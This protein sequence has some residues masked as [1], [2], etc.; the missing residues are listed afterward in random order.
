MTYS[1]Q[2]KDGC[3]YFD[4]GREDMDGSVRLK[5][6]AS[7]HVASVE[8]RI[9]GQWIHGSFELDKLIF[10]DSDASV[11]FI[12]S[13]GI[14]RYLI[15]PAYTDQKGFVVG[16]AGGKGIIYTSS[17]TILHKF[18]EG[19]TSDV[20]YNDGT[21]V[22][23]YTP[24]SPLTWL[25]VPPSNYVVDDWYVYPES[26]TPGARMRIEVKHTTSEVILFEN[27][28]EDSFLHHNG[29]TP[30]TAT[31][32]HFVVNPPMPLVKG[33][34]YD[35]KIEFSADVS[36]YGDATKI[37]ER[38]ITQPIAVHAISCFNKFMTSVTYN[39]GDRV[40]YGEGIWECKVNGTTGAWNAA[41]W[42]DTLAAVAVGA[43][44]D[45]I[46]TAWDKSTGV[47][48]TENQISD[49]KA[50]L[51]VETDPV[52]TAWDKSTGISIT[53]S[54]ISDK[55]WSN[56]G[57]TLQNTAGPTTFVFDDGSTALPRLAMTPTQTTIYCPDIGAH[58]LVNNAGI[59]HTVGA[60][61]VSYTDAGY[62]Y[63]DGTRI[64][65]DV[66]ATACYVY[67]PNGSKSINV[68]NTQIALTGTTEIQNGSLHVSDGSRTRLWTNP[69][70]T[71]MASP[72]GS[73]EIQVNNTEIEVTGNIGFENADSRIYSS[74]NIGYLEF[75]ELGEINW[76]K[77]GDAYDR[78]QINDT[79]YY[80]FAPAGS[81]SIQM[82]DAAI[83]L[84]DGTRDRVAVNSTAS[85]VISPDGD[86]SITVQNGS[87][88]LVGLSFDVNDRYRSR[89]NVGSD[90]VVINSPNATKS[91]TVDNSQILLTAD[92]KNRLLIDSSRSKLISPDGNKS[93][94]VSNNLIDNQTYWFNI[95]DF[96]R[97]RFRSNTDDVS[98]YSPNGVSNLVVS[99]A[100]T[101]I[102]G[103]T[104]V[105]A[106]NQSKSFIIHP[107]SAT[108]SGGSLT[109]KGTSDGASGTYESYSID[110]FWG[111]MRIFSSGNK[112]KVIRMQNVSDI[113]TSPN[114]KL[115]LYVYGNQLLE[116]DQGFNATNETATLS[117]GDVNHYLQAKHSTGLIMGSSNGLTIK[118]G[119]QDR[120][121]VNATETELLSPTDI[122]SLIVRD[123]YMYLFDGFKI[124]FHM[125][126][127]KTQIMS[128]DGDQ[129]FNVSNNACEV[130]EHLL[131]GLDLHVDRSA[132][133]DV[134]LDVLKQSTFGA[135]GAST[136]GN[137]TFVT[138]ARWA[139]NNLGTA[140][141]FQGPKNPSG[142]NYDD[143]NMQAW[144]GHLR[145]GLTSSSGR[146]LIV[147]NDGVGSIELQV[148][149][150]VLVRGNDSFD[151]SGET[152][153]IW[154][155]N[156]SNSIVA[157]YQDHLNIKG[158]NGVS[159]SDRNTADYFLAT[160]GNI[161][162]NNLPT[163]DPQI[164]GVLW[165]D[166]TYIRVSNPS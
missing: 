92:T 68:N 121:R 82:T 5:V 71:G 55:Y 54:Q 80:M 43:E 102:N 66:D 144:E 62:T 150:G 113:A 130:N 114:K 163:Y 165:L 63:H 142:G 85:S 37:K 123:T 91:I 75:A 94:A 13:D 145:M 152:A 141:R 119:T 38:Y 115:L 23:P 15:K 60:T 131:V 160:L 25:M 49:L 28:S 11:S 74:D 46:F 19:A 153:E 7:N 32:T 101:V 97:T 51:T 93:V 57:T 98:M 3:F 53:E 9:K 16:N 17:N 20:T 159:I 64:R 95:G 161:R 86:Q 146:S 90:S 108:Y 29:G 36:L 48:I 118:R 72:D 162:M 50:Y 99:N 105:C 41:N 34:N 65:V 126:N 2:V 128:A 107:Y 77:T 21:T 59:F 47:V 84:K 35:V 157:T 140:L 135:S 69:A 12:G 76:H 104:E 4:N 18:P 52:F 133:I 26:F 44:T 40:W 81:N 154:I 8:E 155:G 78:W 110:N 33:T 129:T 61:S 166:N 137:E 156:T 42:R 103:G 24:A 120:L 148:W 87:I 30:L 151:F 56:D 112:Q 45:P 125:D 106:G 124:R 79:G 6:D 111:A 158:Y 147:S 67:S 132:G 149:G 31:E 70:Y 27:C 88:A 138:L 39:I 117:L 89:F 143:W 134:D 14:Q 136:G 1:P 96:T 127:T 73:S 116:G 139:E 122:Y 22:Y 100:G 58:I 164:T 10:H 83:L 109:L